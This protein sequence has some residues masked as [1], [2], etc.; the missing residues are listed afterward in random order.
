MI[1]AAFTD[2]NALICAF[3]SNLKRGRYFMAVQPEKDG[4]SVTY[5]DS[6]NTDHQMPHI[7]EAVARYYMWRW[8]EQRTKVSVKS[9]SVTLQPH[10]MQI[11]IPGTIQD[12]TLQIGEGEWHAAE[13]FGYCH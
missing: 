4:L 3:R 13:Y 9:E 2:G 7:K 10:W 1:T 11:P 8:W 6:G 12:I 5:S